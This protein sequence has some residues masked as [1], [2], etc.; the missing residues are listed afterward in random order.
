M[1][2]GRALSTV[3]RRI[4]EKANRVVKSTAGHP[5]LRDNTFPR[6]FSGDEGDSAR[7]EQRCLETA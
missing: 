5:K 4:L 1:P 7:N 3:R 2:A 6:T